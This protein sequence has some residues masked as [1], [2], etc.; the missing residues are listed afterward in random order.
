ME[1]LS[2]SRKERT[3]LEVL[4][5][6]KARQITKVKAAA[7][8]GLSYRQTLRAYRRYAKRGA[9]GL[10]HGLRGKPGNRGHDTSHR[11]EV[12]AAYRQSY[13]GFGPTLA[14][15]SEERRGGEE[16]RSR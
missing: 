7:L 15:R 5:R 4:A 1:H 9:A 6:V 10:T 11:R 12:L 14:A 13:G 8:L 3:R 16:W 2:M